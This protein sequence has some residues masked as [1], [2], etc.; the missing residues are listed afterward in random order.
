MN[1]S[2]QLNTRST[3]TLNVSKVRANNGPRL[4]TFI[5]STLKKLS[6]IKVAYKGCCFFSIGRHSCF[7]IQFR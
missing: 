6:E 4:V 5:L 7:S 1:H 3:N 2:N